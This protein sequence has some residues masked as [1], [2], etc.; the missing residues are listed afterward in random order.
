MQS[1]ADRIQR[2]RN[3]T[4]Q[5]PISRGPSAAEVREWHRREAEVQARIAELRRT[6]FYGVVAFDFLPTSC[7]RQ[8]VLRVSRWH[9]KKQ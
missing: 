9:G 3:T 1:E 4:Q 5:Q 2:A 7:H 8:P 6:P